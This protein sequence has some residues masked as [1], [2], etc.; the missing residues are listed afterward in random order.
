[1]AET[2]WNNIYVHYKRSNGKSIRARKY[3]IVHKKAW[4]TNRHSTFFIG[5][6]GKVVEIRDY[7]IMIVAF[8]S[9]NKGRINVYKIALFE[10][11]IEIASRKEA[12]PFVNYPPTS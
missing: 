7:G 1:L 11:E 5:K 9:K 2:K 12:I 8:M 6:V 4:S 3:D 10:D